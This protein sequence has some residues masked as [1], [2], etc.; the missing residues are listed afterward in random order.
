[1]PLIVKGTAGCQLQ[2]GAE[3][4]VDKDGLMNGNATF[5]GPLQAVL[6]GRPLVGI[7]PHP[8]DSRLVCDSESTTFLAN[9]KARSS[10]T[11][12]GLLND[13]SV[14]RIDF[15]GGS[16][17]DP[18]ETHPDFVRFAGTAA[19]PRNGARFD[20]E[21]GEFLG[22]FNGTFRGVT[23][24][25]L[26]SILVNYTYYTTIIPRVNRI[27]KI[28]SNLP[29]FSRPPNVRNYLRIGMPYRQIANVY[30]VTEQFLGSGD[31]GWNRQIY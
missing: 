28:V 1:M 26:P 17:Q 2:P 14:P 22:F 15:A 3:I 19:E 8:M 13:P 24:Y 7:S 18:I 10:A 20:D 25:I 21:T 6:G 12:L 4:S 11:Y 31:G 30:A 16:G 5:E 29:N 9:G 27:G 23:S